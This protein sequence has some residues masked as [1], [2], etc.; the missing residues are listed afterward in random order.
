MVSVK[1]YFQHFQKEHDY[2]HFKKS[3]GKLNITVAYCPLL[4]L[5]LQ[6]KNCKLRPIHSP[7]TISG[8]QT[9]GKP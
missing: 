1:Q 3:G 8:V 4:Q 6:Q 7:L 9:P 2:R 5:L